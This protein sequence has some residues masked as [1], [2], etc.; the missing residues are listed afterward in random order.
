MSPESLLPYHTA[1]SSAGA[2]LFTT[3]R[4]KLQRQLHKGEYDIF[5]YAPIF[6]SDF[7][8]ITKRGEVI[9][10]HNRVRMVT[11]G[12]ASTS[13]LLPLPDVMLLARPATGCDDHGRGQTTK[14]KSRKAAKTLELTRLL[15]LKFVRISI[16]DREKQQLRLK[17]ATGRSCYLH[18]CPPLDSREDLFTYWEKLVYLLRPPVDCQSS[19]YAIP[20]G[21]VICMPVFEE[22]RRTAA[23]VDF[24]GR[25][26]QDQVSVRSLHAGS[27][28][29]GATSAAF[30]GGEG[31][32]LDFY[33]PD[34][35]PDGAKANTKPSQ[36]HEESA[37]GAMTQV[38][39]ADAT[40]GD[41]NV[42][43]SHASE[44][45]STALEVTVTKGLGGSKSNIAMA[46]AAK[47]SLRTRKT[48]L[49]HAAKNL[50][51]RSSTSTSLS[52]EASVTTVGV[53]ATRKTARRK[54][55]EDDE[56][57]L[58]SALPQEDR[59]SEEEDR[60]RVSQ[61]RRGRRERKE[62]REK[63]RAL[64]GSRPRGAAETRPKPAGD[65]AIRKTAGRSSGGR[66]AVKDGKKEKGHGRLGDSKRGAEHKGI[67]HAPITKE[68]RS[69]SAGSSLSSSKRLSR[70]SSFLRNV[71]ASLTPKTVALSHNKDVD[72]LE[73]VVERKRM[74]A[75]METTESGQGLEIAGSVTSEAMETVTV[76]A[77]Q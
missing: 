68:S 3:T 73:K 65:K 59:E 20:A 60:P 21:D 29:A 18:L 48:A 61:A 46:G 58:I 72:L 14:A 57:T 13:P 16:H 63:E 52:P 12:I 49:A 54:A 42:T 25:G 38:A 30:A 39:S 17:F 5:K 70:I 53:E 76:E 1:Q 7:I 32:Q 23:A 77:H 56:G 31:L 47:S 36:L 45:R 24:Q 66:R 33:N 51:Y 15:P 41:L 62:H 43:K 34:P 11:V 71:R 6:E 27:E 28:V 67:S 22:D 37:A 64:R 69:L 26:D 75:I 50:E 35:G 74:E 55:D 40:E 8:Q 9:D 2:G 10:V 44:E 19:T 4:G